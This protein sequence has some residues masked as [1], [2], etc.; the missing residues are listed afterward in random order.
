M[1]YRQLKKRN[2]AFSMMEM[3]LVLGIITLL[4]GAG[5]GGL[6]NVMELGKETKAKA[7]INTISSALRAY[8]SQQLYLPTTRQ[9]IEALVWKPSSRPE[10]KNWKPYLKEKVLTDPW[11]N[12]YIYLRPGKKDGGGFDLYSAGA[13]GVAG[14]SD[15][16]GNWDI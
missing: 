14:N 16:I 3:I 5:V 12:K 2:R 9:G 6:M 15:D 10:P 11:G 8:E 1:K 13:D 7:D 4:V